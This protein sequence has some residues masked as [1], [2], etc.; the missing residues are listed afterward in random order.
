MDDYFS[1][2]KNAEKVSFTSQAV[3]KDTSKEVKCNLWITK[4]FPISNDALI[5]VLKTVNAS[6]DFR[7]LK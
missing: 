5:T 7:V 4:E 1:K 2:R 3:N 6:G